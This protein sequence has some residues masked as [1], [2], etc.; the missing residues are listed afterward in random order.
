MRTYFSVKGT[1]ADVT[2]CGV[3][4]REDLRKTVILHQFDYATKDFMGVIHAGTDCASRVV[5]C[6]EHEMKQ[7]VRNADRNR[8]VA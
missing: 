8:R 4:G 7:R 6:P 2:S 1:T 3:C 5:G